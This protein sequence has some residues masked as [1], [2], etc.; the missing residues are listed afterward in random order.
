MATYVYCCRDDGPLEISAPIGTAPTTTPC[1]TCAGAA[2]RVFTAP[3]LSLG[4]AT[5]RALLDRTSATADAPA[6]VDA[7][8]AVRRAGRPAPADPRLSR[9]PRP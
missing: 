8:P 6:V 7:L 1:P 5:S 9:L 3:R 2:A 4:S